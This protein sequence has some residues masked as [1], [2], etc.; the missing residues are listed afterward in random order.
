MSGGGAGETEMKEEGGN[1]IKRQRWRRS[2]AGMDGQRMKGWERL[3]DYDRWSE[4]MHVAAFKGEWGPRQRGEEGLKYSVWKIRRVQKGRNL[5][6]GRDGALHQLRFNRFTHFTVSPRRILW[7]FF[8]FEIWDCV[9]TKKELQLYGFS[10]TATSWVMHRGLS[11]TMASLRFPAR[12]YLYTY[13]I[14]Y[15]GI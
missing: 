12:T 14:T 2:W 1:K 4:V 15:L 10:R 11:K 13:N 3:E 6:L 8:F 7:V 9:S 5:H